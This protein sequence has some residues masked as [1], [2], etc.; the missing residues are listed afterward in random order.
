MNRRDRKEH[1]RLSIVRAATDLFVEK[2]FHHVLMEEVA[3]RAGVGKGTLY[4]YFS[5][6]EDLYL[7]AIFT[8][9]ERLHREL[10]RAVSEQGTMDGT[11]RK[12]AEEI[13]GYFWKRRDFVT[14][15][16]RLERKRGGKE[17]TIWQRR[18][19]GT[20]EM[21]EAVLRG[22]LSPSPL[23]RTHRRLLAEIFLG[24]LRAVVLHRGYRDEPEGLAR[25]VVDVFLTG[26]VQAGQRKN[27]RSRG[28]GITT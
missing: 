14:L 17:W 1:K 10:Q 13:L 21:I 8:G 23:A 3:G 2:D 24:M 15:V 9:W 4:R 11:L 22:G 27:I 26:V 19:K 12:I 18:R 16:Y 25:L 5:T 28:D 7:A 6:K 20:V